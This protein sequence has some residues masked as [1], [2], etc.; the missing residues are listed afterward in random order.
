MSASEYVLLSH[1]FD[2]QVQKRGEPVEYRRHHRGDILT[3]TS[4]EAAR[5]LKAKAIAPVVADEDEDVAVTPSD[6]S[7]PTE[8]AGNPPAPAPSKTPG[9][10]PAQTALKPEWEAYGVEHGLDPEEV[11]ALSKAEIAAAVD[12]RQ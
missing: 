11:K 8:T 7:D 4:G 1:L 12:A 6:P 3:L 9:E 2:Q 10:R 5:L